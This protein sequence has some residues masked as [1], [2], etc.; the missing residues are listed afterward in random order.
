AF[1]LEHVLVRVRNDD[2]Q[3]MAPQRCAQMVQ[4]QFEE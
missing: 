3:E 1:D 4:V 2:G